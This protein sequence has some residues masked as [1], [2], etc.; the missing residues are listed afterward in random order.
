MNYHHLTIEERCCIRESY[1]KGKSF[2]L[3]LK[4]SCLVFRTFASI[5]YAVLRKL[6]LCNLSFE[7]SCNGA[8]P[9]IFPL[10]IR[11]QSP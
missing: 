7:Q 5:F 8:T 9:D 3:I 10:R 1:K 4:F 11:K 2:C 6:A